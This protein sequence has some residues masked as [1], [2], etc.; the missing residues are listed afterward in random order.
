[1]T[2]HRSGEGYKNISAALKVPKKTVGSIILIWKKF[3][4]T[5]TLPRGGRPAKLSNRGRRAL[6]REVT[7]NP[8]LRQS[9][10]VR[11][12]RWDNLP[13][14]QPSLQYSTNQ[15]YMV[16]WP[17]GSH[18]SVK[19]TGQ[20]AWSLP[21][22]HLKESQT[23]RNIFLWSDET[24]IELFGLNAKHHVWRRPGTIPRMKH[25]S[26]SIMLWGCFQWQGD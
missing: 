4:T 22:K 3:G 23:M 7:K 14:E 20:P 18:S 2:W 21:K 26:G 6:V 12:W 5:K 10:N 25:G 19:G 13:E 17:D 15:A 1:M 9:S 16:E 11:L 8:S 24:K